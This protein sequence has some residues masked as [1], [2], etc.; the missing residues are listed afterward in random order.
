MNRSLLS[1]LAALVA[2]LIMATPAWAALS[3]EDIKEM[4]KVG[5]PD[6]III[7]TI[8]NSEEV[9]HL[10]AQDIIDLKQSGISDDVIEAMQSTSGN[11]ESRSVETR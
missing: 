8:S 6:S 7:S 3:V 11:V 4:A 1:C 2:L 5:V 10:S 9:F